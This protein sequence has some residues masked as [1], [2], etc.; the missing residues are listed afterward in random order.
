MKIYLLIIILLY[1]IGFYAQNKCTHIHNCCKTHGRPI[2]DTTV[3]VLQHL[4]SNEGNA[5]AIIIERYR[6]DP[7]ADKWLYKYITETRHKNVQGLKGLKSSLCSNLDFELGNFTGWTC[8]VGTNNGYPAGGWSGTAPVNNRHTIESGGNDQ[9]GNFPKKAP[10]GGNFSVRLG[11][12]SV[13]AQAEQLIF[14]FVVGPQDTN[15]IY[16]YAVVFEDPGHTWEEQPYFELKIYD[17]SNQVIPCSYQQY[18]A[19]GN[20][21]GFQSAGN[22]VWYK[23]WTTVGINLSPYVGQT[24]TIV[25]TSADCSKSGHF[26]YGYIDFICPSTLLTQTNSYCDDVTS[27]TLTV[28]NIDQGMLYQWSTGETT[29]SI[30]IN[31]QNYNGSNVSVLINT[32]VGLCGFWYVFPIEIIDLTPQFNFSTNCLTV[33]FNDLSTTNIGN[34][35]SWSWNFGNGATSNQQNPSYT[36]TNPGTY[37][38]TLTVTNGNCQKS[39][40]QQ[41]TVN[42]L[43]TQITS[44]NVTCFGANNGTA[45]ISVSGGTAPYSY[46]WSNNQTSPNISNLPPGIYT[47]T[48]SDATGCSNIQSVTITEPPE[49]QLS[50]VPTNVTCFGGND[51]AALLNI[52]GGTPNYNV[53]WSNGQTGTTATNL[54]AGNYSV[55]VSDQ[56]SCTKVQ[57]ITITEPPQLI[58]SAIA[59]PSSICFGQTSTLTANGALSYNWNIGQGNNLQVS[60]QNTTTYYVTGTDAN[61]CTATT[62]VSVTVIPLPTSTF[63]TTPIPCY[64]NNTI[65]QYTG[66]ASQNATFNWNWNG[67]SAWPG[68]GAGPHQVNWSQTGNIDITL[69]VTENGCTSNPTTIPIFNPTPLVLSTNITDVLCFGGTDGSINLTVSGATPPYTY[70]WNFG[71][72][73]EDLYNITAG[74]YSVTVTDANGC[75]KVIGA[76]VNQPPVLIASLTP[77][78][79][80][81]VGR[82]VFLNITVSGGTTPYQ[83]FWNGQNLSQGIVVTLDTTTS[84]SAYVVDA[85][86]CTSPIMNTTVYV[87]PPINVNL[88]ANTYNVCP[89]DPVML[90]PVITGGVGPPYLIHNHN[91]NVVTPP[92]YIYPTESGWYGVIVEDVC[93][94]W[95][96]SSVY[97]N[98]YPLPPINILAD[99]LQGCVPFTVHFIETSPDSGQTYQWNFGDQTNLSLAK[100]PVHTYTTPG[101]Y[102]VSIT[103]TS[104]QGCKR[105][106]TINDMIKVWPKPNA[107]FTW[108]PEVASEIKPLINFNN[109]STF[110]IEYLWS[111]GDGDSSSMINP[112]HKFPAKGEYEVQLIAISDKGCKDTARAIIKILEQYTFYAPTAFSPDGDRNNDYFFIFA[113]G[114][115]EEGFLLEIY[116]RWGE[117]IWK[118][119]KFYKDLDRSER[120]DGKVKNNEIAPVGTYT[121]RCLFKDILNNNHEEVGSITIIR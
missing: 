79:Y 42:L 70:Q 48:I 38:V 35:T 36:Y 18:I 77:N 120:W 91:G 74:I 93:G 105:T 26:G 63:T 16:K 68:T 4:I 89:N 81:C 66:N 47:V 30:N 25:V 101:T 8:Q 22:G 28:P 20:I 34:I 6:E 88:I 113:H 23:N 110:A 94:S 10:G 118:T 19:G 58:V 98:V 114:I 92:I 40:S 67:G 117:I 62:E 86:G 76:T 13:G 116:D 54:I 73:T 104:A 2:E 45:S 41:V 37:N 75:T 50:I 82:P 64:G 100:N 29:P 96:T 109:L 15:F 49:L 99:T 85:N 11:N 39:I 107:L 112:Y 3:N 55:T 12:N 27:A 119:D 111:F 72:T 33:N 32:S 65:V 7:L 83:Y 102:D 106:L 84:Y 121:W 59:N 52:N 17:G 46:L 90:T 21:P 14:T 1:A 51:G 69:T 53:L 56:N 44:T 95:D 60:P 103:V 24:L 43:N 97:I 108:N 78:Q 61:G 80:T 115:K 9:Y 71:S 31:P 57:N 87:A 5:E